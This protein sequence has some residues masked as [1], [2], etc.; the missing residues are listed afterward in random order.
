MKCYIESEREKSMRRLV[1]VT[2]V[3]LLVLNMLAPFRFGLA[4]PSQARVTVPDDYPTI[5]AA[6]NASSPGATIF[7]KAGTYHEHVT[8]NKSLSLFGETAKNTIIDG[9]D[10]GGNVV[11][12]VADNVTLSGLTVRN[13]QVGSSGIR[14]DSRNNCNVSDSYIVNNW[15]GILLHQCSGSYLTENDIRNNGDGIHIESFSKNDAVIGNTMIGQTFYGVHLISSANISIT[16]NI[17]SNNDYGIYLDS[18]SNNQITK[19][20]ASYNGYGLYLDISSNNSVVGNSITGNNRYGVF[21]YNYSSNNVFYNNAFG[22]NKQQINGTRGQENMWDNN[23]KGNY[24]SDYLA[25][26]PNATE[27]DGLGYWNTPYIIDAE[28]TD[29]YPLVSLATVIEFPSFI[30]LFLCMLICF[31][32]FMAFSTKHRCIQKIKGLSH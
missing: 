13:S 8:I 7:V 15:Y 17:V 14:V 9:D 3:T 29:H 27:I 12:I 22:A 11:Y 19:N 25:K 28:N 31:A 10:N 2:V 23:G 4:K 21:F 1:L 26:Y 20:N 32:I 6:V 18:S 30:F 5:Q 24:W 16:N